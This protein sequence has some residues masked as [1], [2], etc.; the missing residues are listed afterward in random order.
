VSN[1]LRAPARRRRVS[2]YGTPG[3]EKNQD[4]LKEKSMPAQGNFDRASASCIGRDPG[5]VRR[6][7]E[8]T[9]VRTS[10][11]FGQTPSAGDDRQSRLHGEVGM[12]PEGRAHAGS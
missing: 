10:D 11:N 9:Y 3:V 4:H 2:T 6:A 7:V 8:E 1:N 12:L 5:A